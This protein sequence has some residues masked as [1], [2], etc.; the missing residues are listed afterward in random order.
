M[1]DAG[2]S[3]TSNPTGSIN[4]APNL[5][6]HGSGSNPGGLPAFDLTQDGTGT[7]TAG[8]ITLFGSDAVTTGGAITTN[9]G[10]LYVSAGSGAITLNSN[11]TLGTGLVSFGAD[12]SYSNDQKVLG[13]VISA[14]GNVDITNNANVTITTPGSFSAGSTTLAFNNGTGTLTMRATDFSLASSTVSGNANETIVLEPYATSTNIDVGG[15]SFV[16]VASL[17]KF[18]GSKSVTVGRSDSTGTATVTANVSLA[19]SDTL[20]IRSGAVT[21]GAGSVT[22]SGGHLTLEAVQGNIS[23]G[24]AATASSRLTLRAPGASALVNGAG[25]LTASSLLLDGSTATFTPT[26]THNLATIAGNVGAVSFTQAGA[27]NVGTISSF[28][29]LQADGTVFLRT[30]GA[31][32]DLTLN[33]AVSGNGSGDAVVLA[34][35]RNFINNAGAS[36]LSVTGGGR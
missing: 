2:N 36:A 29:G 27:F 1:L 33:Q 10:N 12:G 23:L 4:N 25:N 26:G 15:A 22:N 20:T 3:N 35:G 13:G 30:T 16:S 17:A 24:N 32:S 7:P 19:A 6:V 18:T 11:M 21:L 28:N 34:S 5:I 8:S 14:N 31:T 9:G